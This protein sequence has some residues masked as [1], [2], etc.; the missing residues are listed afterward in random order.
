M[1][2]C[3]WSAVAVTLLALV[4]LAPLPAVAQAGPPAKAAA[5]AEKPLEPLAHLVGGQWR[6]RLTMLDGTVI[7]AR[8]VFEWG[9]GGTILKSKTYG[10]VG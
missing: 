4:A 2:T 1:K 3:T 7:R 8:H 5:E 6:G 10:A 9:L